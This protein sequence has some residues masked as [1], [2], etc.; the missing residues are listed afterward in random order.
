MIK[1]NFTIA[2]V[3]FVKENVEVKEG[4]RGEEKCGG[5]GECDKLGCLLLGNTSDSSGA[6]PKGCIAEY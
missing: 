3:M 5:G 1:K 2:P 4:G 6:S